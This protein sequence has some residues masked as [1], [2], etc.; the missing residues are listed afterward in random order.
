MKRFAR[1]IPYLRRIQDGL[2][3]LRRHVAALEQANAALEQANAGD[4]QRL[5]TLLPTSGLA[6]PAVAPVY[7]I[8]QSWTD[9]GGVFLNGW[10]HA[11]P[12][13]VRRVELLCIGHCAGT[14][15]LLPRQDV[16]AHYTGLP[17]R[18]AAGFTLYLACPPR[19][20]LVLA[21]HTDAGIG[22]TVLELPMRADQKE[23]D[24]TRARE[25]FVG[26]M[27]ASSGTVL[28][29]GA[30]RVGS[31]TE[32]WRK[33]FEPAC[34]YLANDIHPAPGIDIVGD[35][36]TLSSRTGRS[37][38]DGVFSVAVLE[39]LAAPWI[40][41][42]EINRCLKVGGETFHITHQSYPVHELPNDY[43]R[44]SDQALRSLFGSAHGFEVLECGMAFPVTI[45]PP[46]FMRHS[47]WLSI[48]LGRGYGQS[49]IRARKVAELGAS[50]A[51][52]SSE[53]LT[54]LSSAYPCPSV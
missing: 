45:T 4:S 11:G 9:S 34:R 3:G 19:L 37:A 8:D 12:T 52:W 42:A 54:E 47:P 36:H 27:R 49:Y 17:P 1:A 15:E 53:L 32:C 50:A 18:G 6:D 51:Q 26:A 48:P 2:D 5:R 38:V 35:A 10:V 16:A 14:S 24:D 40:A 43:F 28:E 7:F 30:R 23:P 33:R 41:A 46:T 22:E 44:M 29:I 20:P 13:V 39:H 21:V 31:L 25:A